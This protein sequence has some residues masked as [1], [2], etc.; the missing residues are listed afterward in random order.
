MMVWEK[1]SKKNA[2]LSTKGVLTDDQ[3][4][5]V[6][7]AKEALAKRNLAMLGA[8]LAHNG[9]PKSGRKEELTERI[10]E[11]Q[12]MGVPPKCS[13]CDKTKLKWSRE[14][15]AYSCPGYFDEEIKSLK[16]CRGPGEVDSVNR[17]P[18]QELTA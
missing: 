13:L 3:F 5:A 8:M 4:L 17:T 2:K 11:C 18:W 12:I 10:A 1:Y 14:T 16:R 15:G 6:G 9:L 7:N